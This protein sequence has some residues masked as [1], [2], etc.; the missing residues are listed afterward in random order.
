M[1]SKFLTLMTAGLMAFALT[2]CSDDSSSGTTNA[3]IDEPTSSAEG[4]PSEDEQP[5][6]EE[7]EDKSSS[8]TATVSSS[9]EGAVKKTYKYYGAELAG[10]EQFTYGR[11]EAKMKMVSFS[12]TVS[13]MFLYF[14]DSWMLK[15]NKWNEID[16]EVIG[17]SKTK[18]QSNLITREPNATG[19]D[20]GKQY[21]EA[22]HDFGFDAT[23]DFHVYAIEWTPEYIAWFVDDKEIRRNNVGDD[24]KTVHDQV[25]YMTLQQSLRFNLWSSK[26]VEW[27]GKFDGEKELANGPAVQ[28]IE[29]VKVWAYDKEAKEFT[30]LWTD[31]FEGSSL[32]RTHWNTGNWEMENVMLK[33]ANVVVEDGKCKLLMTRE[34]VEE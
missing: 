10:K 29:Y 15:E 6:G 11:F 32:N 27:V 13:S 31:E 14:D 16:I 19:V 18:W 24:H 4:T 28:E 21:S 34:E 3:P 17:T 20:N 7:N 25:E 12:G 8:S 2:A 1:K 22:K 33:A 5:S 30:E 23:E 9:S 26:A